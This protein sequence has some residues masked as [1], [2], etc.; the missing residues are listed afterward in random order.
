M[1]YIDKVADELVYDTYHV[2]K[3]RLER[4]VEKAKKGDRRKHV[5]DATLE[6]AEN[7]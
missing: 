3:Q 2:N 4:A 1:V 6:I 7:L 5:I